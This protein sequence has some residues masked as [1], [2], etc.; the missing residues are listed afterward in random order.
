VWPSRFVG[1]QSLR[2]ALQVNASVRRTTAAMRDLEQL[3]DDREPGIELI[4]EWVDSAAVSTQLLPP[5]LA[6]AEILAGLQ[7]TTRSPLGALAYDTGGLLIDDG[8]VR[9]LGSGHPQ[10]TRDLLRWNEGR[11]QHF[12]LVA[13]DAV[14]GFFA[15]NG[16]G[17]GSDLQQMY[18]WAPDEWEWEP[19]GL[20]F[21]ALLQSLLQGSIDKFYS[22][23]R[24]PSWR[25][26]L[27]AVSADQCFAFY[28]FLWT[29]EGS[30]SSS[31]RGV[32][33]SAEAFD[34]KVSM[35]QQLEHGV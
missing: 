28:P 11:S 34:L 14:G 10:F 9:F 16:G 23:L 30:V 6:R 2:R 17:L 33:S 12:F 15:I 24:W 5:N 19:L 31:H 27:A 7:I 1:G 26:D 13:D 21:S 29:R 8:W 22:D 18:Y 32:V 20:S 4:R 3:V 25:A 35:I